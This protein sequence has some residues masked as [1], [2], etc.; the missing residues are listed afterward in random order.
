MFCNRFNK[1][2]QTA[3]EDRFS[4]FTKGWVPLF[5]GLVEATIIV[6]GGNSAGHVWDNTHTGLIDN[7]GLD[8]T[9][10]DVAS[11]SKCAVSQSG[12]GKI[13]FLSMKLSE[14]KKIFMIQLAFRTDECCQYQGKNVKVQVGSS[15]QYNDNY[16][17]CKEIN[18]L[19]GTGL[20]A[21][22]CDQVHEG[23]YVFLS[24]DQSYLTICEAKVYVKAC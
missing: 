3:I 13:P 6:T 1:R 5:P 16:P 23:Q 14:S 20:V 21:Y 10:A 2:A 15:R 7:D 9:Y 12:S 17:V 8:G 19:T 24:N 11:L 4:H 18:Q 22:K